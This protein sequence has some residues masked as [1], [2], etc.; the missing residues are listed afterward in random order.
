MFNGF[1][2]LH[3]HTT[4][5]DGT[6]TPRGIV[7]LAQ[8]RDVKYIAITD[9]DTVAGVTEAL[10]AGTELGINVISGVEIG[11]DWLGEEIHILGYGIDHT[12]VE[13]NKALDGLLTNRNQRNQLV[14]DKLNGLGLS[15]TL[16]DVVKAAGGNVIGRNHFAK[17][18]V[19]KGYV[20]SVQEA[21]DCYL[22]DG[23]P[24]FL[25][26]QNPSPQQGITWIKQAGG[27]AV[28]AHPWLIRRSTP[29][30]V[31]AG[32]LPFGLGGIEVWY[33]KHSAEQAATLA[34]L[35]KHHN[36]LITGGSDYHGAGKEGAELG[37]P[38]QGQKLPAANVSLAQ[39]QGK[40]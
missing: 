38:F 26:R 12:N 35:A 28:L 14:V 16:A 11:V 5:S 31:V 34:E 39:L 30:Q 4:A 17:V 21:F 18:L 19:A 6:V 13:L 15:L 2:D 24:G 27:I 1:V 40:D 22:A 7:Q 32:L 3:I 20:N 8:Q 36:L 37:L 23:K 25:P 9:H 10:Q 33:S 29:A